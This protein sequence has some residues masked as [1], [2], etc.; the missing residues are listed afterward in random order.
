MLVVAL[1]HVP[2]APELP[3]LSELVELPRVPLAEGLAMDDAQLADVEAG[4]FQVALEGFEVLIQDNS[5]GEF[6]MSIAESAFG[7]AQGLFTTIQAVN[8]AVDLTII[9]NIFL[10]QQN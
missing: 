5:A 9:V 10:T 4:D 2:G 6:T 7:S 1:P 3:R 8:S